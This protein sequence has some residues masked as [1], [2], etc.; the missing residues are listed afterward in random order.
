MDASGKPRSLGAYA[1][2]YFFGVRANENVA[3]T[4]S[5]V[6]YAA[7]GAGNDYPAP[8]P[9]LS[10]LCSV[11]IR[12]QSGS[13]EVRAKG[14]AER[15]RN[16]DRPD[17]YGHQWP[18]RHRFLAG[19]KIFICLGGSRPAGWI[20]VEVEDR[21]RRGDS[22]RA[23]WIV[24]GDD[25]HFPRRR[26]YLRGECELPRRHGSILDFCGGHRRDGRGETDHHLHYAARLAPES[27]GHQAVIRMH[28][29][30]HARGNRYTNLRGL[31]AL[32][33]RR[34]QR[35]GYDRRTRQANENE[36]SHLRAHLGAAFKRWL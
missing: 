22:L 14:S 29:G 21:N 28:D 7:G 3:A 25:R 36:R 19:Q 12:R 17:A 13:G 5:S 1:V 2:E 30:R 24:P 26:I 31:A 8:Q 23:A 35:N 9:G 32:P 4:N 33:T 16:A 18:A 20:G 6:E 34:R 15:A 27:A 11:R 10:R